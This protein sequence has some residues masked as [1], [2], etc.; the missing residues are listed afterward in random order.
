MKILLTFILINLTNAFSQQYNIR[1]AF[2]NYSFDK[3]TELIPSI[4]GTNRLFV[5]QQRGL[6][7]VFKNDTTI[8]NIKVFLNLTNV[9]AQTGYEGGLMGM[10]F[11]PN[12]KNNRYFYVHYSYIDSGSNVFSRISRFTTS[13]INPDSA[14]LS[15]EYILMTVAE[16]F[17]PHKGG[18]IEFGP[19]GYL[20]IAKGDGGTDLDSVGNAQ[21]KFNLMGKILRIDVNSVSPGRNYSV[22]VSNPYYGNTLGYKDEIYAYGFRNP[23]KFSIDPVTNRLWAGDVG[24]HNYEEIDIVEKGK[25]YGWNKLEG[26]H[27]LGTCDTSGMNFTRPVFE[28]DHSAGAQAV[29]AGY[30]YRGLNFPSL[31]GK[32]IYADLGLANVYAITYDGI[33]VTANT[34]LNNYWGY[35]ISTLGISED[36]NEIFI[37]RF[38]SGAIFRLVNNLSVKVKLK[39]LIEGFF[40]NNKLN[41]KDTITV[42]LRNSAAPFNLVSSS[43]SILDSVN[44]F[45]TFNFENVNSGNYYLQIKYKNSIETWSKIVSLSSAALN[46]FDLTSSQSQAFGNNLKL[47]NNMYCIYSGD[48]NQDGAV[49]II[50]VSSVDNDAKNFRSGLTATDLTGDRFVDV[51]DLTIVDNNGYNFVSRIIP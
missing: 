15:S 20:Y 31:Y 19:D 25:N 46:N 3:P 51:S 33:N 44:Y 13:L 49:E 29:I 5:L 26:Y 2:I 30:V 12:Y 10:A 9:V 40:N 41:L 45:G 39:M 24:E 16:P 14:I 34:L 8:N 36:R 4:D 48:V 11:H 28:Y 22:P 47:K 17:R 7:Y 21:S 38:Y 32:Y 43:K 1:Q 42:N 37:M 50:D 18:R 35:Y 23:W 27:C 6:A